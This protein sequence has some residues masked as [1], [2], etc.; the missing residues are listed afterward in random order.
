[1][2]RFLGCV[3]A[4]LLAWCIGKALNVPVWRDGWDIGDRCDLAYLAFA[5]C[6]LLTR[7]AK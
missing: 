7:K 4:A 1:M 6:W 2:S 3:M 5:A